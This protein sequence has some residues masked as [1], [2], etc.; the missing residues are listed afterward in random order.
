MSGADEAT[1]HVEQAT[2]TPSCEPARPRP[3]PGQHLA[4]ALFVL[5]YWMVVGVWLQDVDLAQPPAFW[6]EQVAAFPLLGMIPTWVVS[7]LATFASWAAARHILIPF[8]AGWLLANAV[9]DG[10]V[11]SFY[12]FPTRAE[13][14]RFLQRLQQQ[15]SDGTVG[16]SPRRLHPTVMLTLITAPFAFLFLLL[17]VISVVGPATLRGSALYNALLVILGGAW[18]VMVVAYLLSQFMGDAP[19]PGLRLQRETLDEM[20]KTQALLRVGGPGRVIVGNSDAAITEYNGR[21]CRVLGPGAHRLRSFEYVSDVVD[22]RPQERHGEIHAMTRDGIGVSVD[23][24]VTFRIDRDDRH[25]GDE[26]GSNGDAPRPTKEQLY[27]FG[28]RAVAQAAYDETLVPDSQGSQTRGAQAL[29]WSSRPLTVVAREFRQAL[30]ETPLVELFD[31][32]SSERALHANLLKNIRR[33]SRASLHDD[34]IELISLH[35]GP[36]QAQE[37]VLTKNLNGWRSFWQEHRIREQESEA[38]TAALAKRARIEAEV[39]MLHAVLESIQQAQYEDGIHL[40]R[41][42]VA[43]RLL[44]ALDGATCDL[45]PAEAEEG[46][47]GQDALERLRVLHDR[48]S[49]GDARS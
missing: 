46:E 41:D 2:D 10:F 1:P 38:Q 4:I 42:E 26:T 44:Q 36:L 11:Q 35:L 6:Q 47:E 20:R 13:A 17:I 27:L 29:L 25:F 45:P 39:R 23:V 34:G 14:A 40:S 5:S 8:V 7:Y 33:D 43:R 31:P 21:F 28:Q 19:A 48:L 3:M 22:L 32:G 16:A 12:N 24:S 15:R 30:S 49:P 37:E 9:G 18:F